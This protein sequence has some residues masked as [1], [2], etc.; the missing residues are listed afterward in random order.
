MD[1]P[2]QN[3]PR[4]RV[5]SNHVESW[6]VRANDPRSPRA[7]W[8]KA[9]VLIRGGGS[10]LAQAW[11]SVFD[12]DRTL[13]ICQDIPLDE[14]TFDAGSGGQRFQVGGLR[15]RLDKDAGTTSGELASTRGSVSWAMTFD[16]QAGSLGQ[17]MSLFPSEKLIDAGF[18]KNKLLTPFPLAIFGGSITWNDETW[19]LSGW[20]GMQGHNWGTAHSP[21]YAWGQ[22]VF[23]KPESGAPVA[24]AEAASGRI[25]LGR[26]RSPLMSMMVLRHGEEEYR[27]DGIVDL[28]RQHPRLEFPA[29][30]LRMRG[31][32]GTATLSMAG[33]P[34]RMVCLAYQNPRRSTSYCLNSKTTPVR[35]T[36]TPRKGDAFELSSPHGGA[37]EFLRPHPTPDVQ[38]VV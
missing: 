6:F 37:L 7:V 26:W 19:D 23:T 12:A 5:P 15:M 21:E 17:P 28:W 24:L 2:A 3:A 32:Q 14:A 25:Q 35:L 27:F 36:V 9:T 30:H 33:S 34:S 16:R 4:F 20:H 10:A 18:P 31:H 8:L 13:A 11:I 22:C 29:W 1:A 38:P